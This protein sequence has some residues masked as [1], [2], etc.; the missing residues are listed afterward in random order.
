MVQ[1]IAKWASALS[2]ATMAIAGVVTIV[3][4]DTEEVQRSDPVSSDVH[5]VKTEIPEVR[6]KNE[7]TM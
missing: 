6:V 5:R 7:P 2:I 3:L 1:G 4:G